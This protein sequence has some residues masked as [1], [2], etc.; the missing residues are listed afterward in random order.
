MAKKLN[1]SQPILSHM[2]QD[3]PH[4]YCVNGTGPGIVGGNNTS[5]CNAGGVA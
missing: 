2:E 1:Y 3:N 5:T 4:S